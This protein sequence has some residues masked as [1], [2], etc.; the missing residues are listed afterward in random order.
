M[1]SSIAVLEGLMTSTLF[2]FARSLIFVTSALV[3]GPTTNFIPAPI[4]VL[5]FCTAVS[6]FV[7]VSSTLNSSL[8]H[9]PFS[10]R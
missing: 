7:A 3:I 1:A 10:W 4:R 2:W 9:A 5:S 8:N 6:G